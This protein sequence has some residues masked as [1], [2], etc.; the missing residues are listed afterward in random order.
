[1]SN[2]EILDNAPESATHVSDNGVYYRYDSDFIPAVYWARGEEWLENNEI[3]HLCSSLSNITRIAVLEGRLAY[4][5]RLAVK[6]YYYTEEELGHLIMVKQRE[7]VK[8]YKKE[9]GE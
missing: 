7:A 9:Q 6:G 4:Y 8:A 2:Q 3:T 5:E 1:M